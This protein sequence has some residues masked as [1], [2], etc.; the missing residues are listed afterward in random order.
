MLFYRLSLS[1][2]FFKHDLGGDVSSGASP[3]FL[4][5]HEFQH[6]YRMKR[7]SLQMLV[8]LIQDH[9]VFHPP[10]IEKDENNLQQHTN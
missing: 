10:H 7:V 8:L 6:K 2:N 4:S 3:A 9:P 1:D 5:D